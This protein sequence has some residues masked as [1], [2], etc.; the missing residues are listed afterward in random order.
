MRRSLV[1]HV[2]SILLLSLTLLLASA[3]PNLDPG[4]NLA[5]VD[6]IEREARP[7]LLRGVDKRSLKRRCHYVGTFFARQVCLLNLSFLSALRLC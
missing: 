6:L 4:S 5:P 3:N 1:A 2:F 7:P